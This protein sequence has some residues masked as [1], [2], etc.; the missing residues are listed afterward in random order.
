MLDSCIKKKIF[1]EL[2]VGFQSSFSSPHLKFT[3]LHFYWVAASVDT[4]RSPVGTGRSPVDTSSSPRVAGVALDGTGWRV[5]QL[6]HHTSIGVFLLFPLKSGECST[7]RTLI[8]AETAS[9][10]D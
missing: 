2:L 4:S 1:I 3:R 7:G 8:T 5:V 9:T 10:G 6:F